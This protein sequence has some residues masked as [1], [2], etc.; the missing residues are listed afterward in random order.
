MYEL[1]ILFNESSLFSLRGG[2]VI[3][4]SGHNHKHNTCSQHNYEHKSIFRGDARKHNTL[5]FEHNVAKPSQ[6][7]VNACDEQNYKPIW[8]I[9]RCI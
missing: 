3:S 8:C 7:P 5:F 1:N 4:F 2:W 6:Q 9:Q